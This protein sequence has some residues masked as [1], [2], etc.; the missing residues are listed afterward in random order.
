MAAITTTRSERRKIRRD[1]TS[2]SSRMSSKAT[3]TQ[4][5]WQPSGP[6][7]HGYRPADFTAY[8]AGAVPL[9]RFVRTEEV[10]NAVLF[11]ASAQRSFV[12]NAE[13]AIDGGLNQV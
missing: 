11:L 8:L 13:L 6:L 10:A 2:S 7:P 5:D 1:T 4:S 9:G 3:N 12:T